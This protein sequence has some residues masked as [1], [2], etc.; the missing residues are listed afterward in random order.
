MVARIQPGGEQQV[1]PAPR[2]SV[3]KG[4][5]RITPVAE[6]HSIACRLDEGEWHVYSG[7]IDLQGYK[8]IEAKA[9]RYG[10]E[11]SD[12]VTGP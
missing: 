5:V 12:L 9:V 2:V 11:K 8:I 3:E 7:L 6:G 4:R 1:T 10:W